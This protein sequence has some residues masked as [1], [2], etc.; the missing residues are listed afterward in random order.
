[1]Q[2]GDS[3]KQV[4]EPT[5]PPPHLLNQL[6]E[7]I[8]YRNYSLQ[9]EKTYVYWVWNARVR[10]PVMPVQHSGASRATVPVDAGPLASGRA[11]V[12]DKGAIVNDFFVAWIWPYA[13]IRP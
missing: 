2:Y 3:V 4:S 8:C 7:R 9:T 11:T 13:W 12:M 1:M 5:L 10:I 6:C